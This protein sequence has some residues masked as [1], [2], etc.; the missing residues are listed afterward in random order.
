MADVKALK[1]L[2][3]K[4][5][6]GF[7][8]KELLEI[9]NSKKNELCVFVGDARTYGVKPTQFGNATFLLGSFLA[10]NLRNG[11]RFK[12]TKLYLPNDVAENVV[13]ELDNREDRTQPVH[14]KVQVE[15]AVSKKSKGGYTYVASEITTPEALD[16]EAELLKML[17]APKKAA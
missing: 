17:P 6:M 7:D 15:V 13:A 11:E 5:V 1:K 14:F 12:S 2:S 3:V 8:E 4:E 16:R 10:V 9:A